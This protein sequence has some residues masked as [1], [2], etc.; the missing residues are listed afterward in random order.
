MSDMAARERGPGGGLLA[1]VV[2]V[3]V[4]LAGLWVLLL[5]VLALGQ[6]TLSS[7]F[8]QMGLWV[9]LLLAAAGLATLGCLVAL[10]LLGLK[11][12]L[13]PAAVF[14]VLAVLPWVVGTVGSVR[15]AEEMAGALQNVNPADRMFISALGFRESLTARAVG[16][17]FSAALLALTGLG[18]G[19]GAL[20]ARLFQRGS[21]SASWGSTAALCGTLALAIASLSVPVFVQR[22]VLEAVA[23]LGGAERALLLSRAAVAIPG[24]ARL[25]LLGQVALVVVLGV[26]VWAGRREDGRWSPGRGL[27]VV[28]GLVPVVGLHAYTNR[29]LPEL[30]RQLATPFWASTEDFQPSTVAGGQSTER[31]PP[32]LVTRTHLVSLLGGAPVP[33]DGALERALHIWRPRELD[34]GEPEEGMPRYQPELVLAVDARVEGTRLRALVD[35]AQAAGARS[36]RFVGLGE[37]D[38]MSSLL[39]Q[40][41]LLAPYSRPT[42]V[43]PRVGLPSGLVSGQAL[44]S[45]YARLETTGAVTVTPRHGGRG[46]PMTVDPTQPLAPLEE[47]SSDMTEP[48]PQAR[49]V[50]LEP[51]P[52]TTAEHVVRVVERLARRSTPEAPLVP[53]LTGG[54]PLVVEDTGE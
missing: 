17:G 29:H 18:L 54:S 36:M 47:D 40:E 44:E 39:E 50:F 24:A 32:D 34:A 43:T 26:G 7:G 11:P 30:A 33:L 14:L 15:M 3:V 22:Q 27:A 45:W 2:A 49:P 41:P 13:A 31:L 35:A 5:A 20:V 52:G 46:E 42:R 51:G 1:P 6:E 25:A 48:S 38:V 19:V 12:R 9:Y 28:L 8:E 53:I 4:V 16:G 37:P 10:V 23:T 21:R